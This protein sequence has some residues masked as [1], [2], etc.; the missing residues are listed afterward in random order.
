MKLLGFT[1]YVAISLFFGAIGLIIIIIILIKPI[2]SKYKYV[3]R[4]DYKAIYADSFEIK[5][6]TLIVKNSNGTTVKIGEHW[7]IQK[8]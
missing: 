8:N 1:Y 4:G 5:D 2:P 7:N 3:I 6:D